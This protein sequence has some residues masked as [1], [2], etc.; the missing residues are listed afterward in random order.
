L[1]TPAISVDPF[2]LA[3]QHGLQH[4]LP[5]LSR[6]RNTVIASRIIHFVVN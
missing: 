5:S 6:Q 4:M 3:R 1:S 2:E